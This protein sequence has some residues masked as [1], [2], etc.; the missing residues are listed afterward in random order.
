[1]IFSLGKESL[2]MMGKV[3]YHEGMTTPTTPIICRGTCGRTALPHTHTGPKIHL[4]VTRGV[5][6]TTPQGG[7]P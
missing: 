4:V 6:M 3:S 5:A 1:M 7:T 2:D